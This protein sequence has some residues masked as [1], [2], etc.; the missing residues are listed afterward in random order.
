MTLVFYPMSDKFELTNT[1]KR[2]AQLVMG[3]ESIATVEMGSVLRVF[4]VFIYW[5]ETNPTTLRF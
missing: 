3:I 5:E 2:M 1:S 4:Y